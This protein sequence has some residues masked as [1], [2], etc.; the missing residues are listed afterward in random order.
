MKKLE[1]RHGYPLRE[2]WGVESKK[3]FRNAA[4]GRIKAVEGKQLADKGRYVLSVVVGRGVR[5]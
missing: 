3:L 4:R 5:A 1:R 2:G